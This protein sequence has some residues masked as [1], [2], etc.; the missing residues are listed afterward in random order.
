VP[1]HVAS[2]NEINSVVVD[3]LYFPFT[4]RHCKDLFFDEAEEIR[5]KYQ[6]VDNPI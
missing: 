3:G 6:D 5:E 4:G 2:N 1:K